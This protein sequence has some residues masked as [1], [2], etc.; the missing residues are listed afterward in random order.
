[1]SYFQLIFYNVVGPH[2]QSRT[3]PLRMCSH[4]SF[5][6]I[7]VTSY[8]LT[9][10]NFHVFTLGTN[11]TL[12][13]FHPDRDHL[14]SSDF[15]S[16]L[17]SRGGF[18]PVI[19]F[20]FFI[21]FPVSNKVWTLRQKQVWSQSNRSKFL[22]APSYLAL[23]ISAVYTFIWCIALFILLNSSAACKPTDDRHVF[24]LTEYNVWQS[25]WGQLT[26][27]FFTSSFETVEFQEN[28]QAPLVSFP[29]KVAQEHWT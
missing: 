26:R 21:F 2:F 22:T 5:F 24:V 9:S 3:S 15:W 14:F 17:W 20:Y 7:L 4:C 19:L 29:T 16:R 8:A 27:I 1:M 10:Y 23:R 13:Q 6:P 28:W 12:V 18:T 11:Q 25:H